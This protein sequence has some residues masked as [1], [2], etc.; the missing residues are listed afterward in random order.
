L[1]PLYGGLFFSY[2]CYSADWNSKEWLRLVRYHKTTFG[3]YK[4]E[5]DGPSFFLHSEGRNRP[6]LEYQALL[7][8]IQKNPKGDPNNHPICRF[9]ARTAFLMRQRPD[10]KV[11]QVNCQNFDV[12]RDR[13]ISSN[14]KFIVYGR[15]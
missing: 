3:G 1:G 10:L 4:S 13:K 7:T 12:F 6:D 15:I 2:V 8:G 11:A 5:A 14:E 9:P